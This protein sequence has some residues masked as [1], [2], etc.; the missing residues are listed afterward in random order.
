MDKSA[1]LYRR[2]LGP[3]KNE[4]FECM[5]CVNKTT[6][7]SSKIP[8][9]LTQVEKQARWI[10]QNQFMLCWRHIQFK[11][12]YSQ[13][14]MSGSYL[15]PLSLHRILKNNYVYKY[16]CLL[17][18]S[19]LCFLFTIVCLLYFY[20]PLFVCYTCIYFANCILRWIFSIPIA[21]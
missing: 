4:S 19:I 9:Q 1:L 8:P 15:C 21:M 11:I 16:L 5:V 2:Q 3:T 7:T 18:I 6:Q 12:L 14:Q 17:V 10:I 13:N 20:L